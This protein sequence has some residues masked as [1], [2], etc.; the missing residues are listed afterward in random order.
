MTKI[1]MS[2][3]NSSVNDLSTSLYKLNVF[4]GIVLI[5]IGVF[6]VIKQKSRPKKNRMIA[7]TI[8]I[9]IGVLAIFSGL[10]EL[11]V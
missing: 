7:A 2:L 11:I 4:A 3:A 6:L 9:G 5:I 1:M 8:C 10:I